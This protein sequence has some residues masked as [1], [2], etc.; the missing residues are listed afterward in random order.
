MS[1]YSEQ[2][3]QPNRTRFDRGSVISRNEFS[4][5]IG[6]PDFMT[7]IK[8]SGYDCSLE[9]KQTK[10]IFSIRYAYFY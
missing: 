5:S 3:Q 9:N 6:F 8:S 10:S 7:N 1:R 4:C 2:Q